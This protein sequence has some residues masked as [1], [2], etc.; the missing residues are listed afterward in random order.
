[1][2]P[3]SGTGEPVIRRTY[4]TAMN[5]PDASNKVK[6][7]SGAASVM[8]DGSEPLRTRPV[9]Q[10]VIQVMLADGELTHE[11]RRL[12]IK[13]GTLLFKQEKE[14]KEQPSLIYQTVVEGGDVEGGRIIGRG[15][16]LQ[17]FRDMFETA[18]VNSSLSQDELSAIAMLRSAL[19]IDD[20][21]Y[22][23][24]IEVVEKNLEESVEPK[25]FD[26]VKEDLSGVLDKVGNMF[27]SIIR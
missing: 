24:L 9:F 27:E 13:L 11:E 20:S 12:A 23:L 1:M 16:R 6:S 7:G 8:P 4:P 21:E 3:V 17:I 22:E 15:E 14:L 19:D 2:R 5:P 10:A 26:K 18:F 25:L